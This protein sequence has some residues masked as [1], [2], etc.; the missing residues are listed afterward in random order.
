M[1]GKD[2]APLIPVETGG[3]R[4]RWRSWRSFTT[5]RRPVNQNPVYRNVDMASSMGRAIASSAEQ[6]AAGLARHQATVAP[7]PAV[8]PGAALTR[9]WR[10][11]QRAGRGGVK[12][13][14][15]PSGARLHIPDRPM[16]PTDRPALR[17][18]RLSSFGSTGEFIGG[19]P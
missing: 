6:L 16:I 4:W 8:T 13:E 5:R 12:A 3:R 9:K 15:G 11:K 17:R 19:F 14:I 2:G 1:T 10:D 18:A 7:E